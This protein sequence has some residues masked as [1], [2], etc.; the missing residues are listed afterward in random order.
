MQLTKPF[1][2]FETTYWRTAANVSLT[3]IPSDDR[4][5]GACSKKDPMAAERCD[6]HVQDPSVTIKNTCGLDLI[7]LWREARSAVVHFDKSEGGTGFAVCSD[8]VNDCVIVTANHVVEGADQV[9]FQTL[10]SP[11]ELS[12]K[13]I[14]RDMDNDIAL[15]KPDSNWS[16]ANGLHM[17]PRGE[18]ITENSPVFV[19][20]HPAGLPDQFI[21]PGIVTNPA[22][23]ISSEV[24]NG[25]HPVL[26]PL[27]ES[28]TATMG[29]NSGSPLFDV[30]GH[31]IGV[32]IKA[33]F[34]SQNHSG[35]REDNLRTLSTPI[36]CVE[37]LQRT[38][39]SPK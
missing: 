15:V 23:R 33:N 32:A 28:N 36:S 22:R 12:G 14:A 27:I 26:N 24:Q 17:A 20:G 13:V 38:I 39:S 5:H 34:S 2:N 3:F 37:A 21:S 6:R 4:L 11:K 29:G 7:S 10:G 1:N 31:V 9:A 18:T 16:P 30:H 8:K 19:I 25:D 35:A